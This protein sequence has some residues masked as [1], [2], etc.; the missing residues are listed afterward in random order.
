[1]TQSGVGDKHGKWITVIASAIL[2]FE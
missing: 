1:M 2:I